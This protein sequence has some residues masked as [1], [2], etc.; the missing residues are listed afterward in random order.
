MKWQRLKIIWEYHLK[1][2]I[3]IK[4]GKIDTEDVITALCNEV[5]I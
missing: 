1:K 2:L 4:N 3:D 5:C